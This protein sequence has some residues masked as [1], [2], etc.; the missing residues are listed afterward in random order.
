MEKLDTPANHSRLDP[1]RTYR[2]DFAPDGWGSELRLPPWASTQAVEA[3]ASLLRENAKG[4]V[5]RSVNR[6]TPPWSVPDFIDTGLGC[7]IG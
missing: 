6:P 1:Y 5:N 4:T 7:Q 2:D 3:L